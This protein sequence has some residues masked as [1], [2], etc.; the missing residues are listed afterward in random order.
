MFLSF[1]LLNQNRDILNKMNVFPISDGDTGNNLCSAVEP[2][3]KIDFVSLED[4]LPKCS[5]A[6]LSS[7]RGC[8]GNILSLYVLGLSLNLS[9]NLTD[10]CFRAAS[11][12]WK[13]MYR[14]V[15]GT[16]LTAMKDVPETYESPSDFLFKY[17]ENTH[18]NLIS[19]PDVLTVLKDCQT[20]DSGTYGFM[21]ILCDI[22]RCLTGHV[23]C[24]DIDISLPSKVFEDCPEDKYC[25]EIELFYT[26]QELKSL[27]KKLG[28]ELVYLSSGDKVKIHIHTYDYLEIIEL[29]RNFGKIDTYKIEDMLDNNRRIYI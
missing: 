17:I 1:D 18:K 25:V 10:M 5:D 14:P 24:P 21:L 4:F 22:Y 16:I 27:L 28:S 20:L 9:D 26:G 23:F 8:S 11:F 13:S 3:Q 6:L 2:I 12:A 7:G 15:E 19:G 29:C